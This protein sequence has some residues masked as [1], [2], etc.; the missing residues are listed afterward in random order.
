[1]SA[2]AAM[3]WADAL[4]TAPTLGDAVAECAEGMQ[5]PE[6]GFDL[7]FVF[8][9]PA[10]RDQ[11]VLPELLARHV[12]HRHLLGCSGGGIIGGG[13]E[14]EE[15]PA[16][17]LVGAVLPDVAVTPFALTL[18]DLADIGPGP[19]AWGDR[20][21]L[22]P[23]GAAG[24]VVLA[25]PFS[26]RPEALIEGLEYAYPGVPVVGGL[27][28]GA[29][30]PGEN[31]LFLDGRV[32][33][34]GAVGVALSG[35]L[36][37]ETVVAQGVRGIGRPCVVTR[38]EGQMLY[39]LDGEPVMQAL[40]KLFAELPDEDAE[41]ASRGLFLGVSQRADNDAPGHGDYLIRNVLGAL[42][43]GEA[44]VVGETLH[45]GQIVRFHVRDAASSAE[46]LALLLSAYAQRHPSGPAAGALLF[47]CLGRG[48]HLYGEP[49]HDTTAFKR[50]VGEAPLGGFFCNGEIGPVGEG[51][52]LHGYTSAFALFHPEPHPDPAPDGA[53]G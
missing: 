24:F 13:H 46:D 38:S 51:T 5:A 6:G 26:F 25:D 11:I 34:A 3:H 32:L 41:R 10:Y 44:I 36:R 40:E 16:L 52:Y 14:V 33:G 29:G 8:A 43:G 23:G 15:G 35:A 19:G 4:S 20:I 18:D 30:A 22:E 28:S 42:E 50:I 2:A 9:S 27:A 1:M 53:P 31:Q 7:L 12:P 39:E 47:S 49:D 37:L 21:G 45:D 17:S 48:E